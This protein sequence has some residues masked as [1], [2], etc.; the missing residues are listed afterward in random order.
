MVLMEMGLGTK[1]LEVCLEPSS[2]EGIETQEKG[3]ENL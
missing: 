2:Y 3:R 1:S